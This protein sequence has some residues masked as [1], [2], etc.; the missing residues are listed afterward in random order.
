MKQELRRMIRQRKAAMPRERLQAM[1]ESVCRQVMLSQ[2]WHEAKVLLLYH[3]L[4]DEVD[5]ALLIREAEACGKQVLLPVVVGDVL[6]LRRYEGDQ[7]M[8][9][10]PFG[11]KEP[12]GTVFPPAEY[13]QITLAIVPGMAFD[14]EGYR[15]GRGRGYYDKLLPLLSHAWKMGICWDF[16]LLENIPCEPHDVKMDCVIR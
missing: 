13:G 2:P 14:C 3:S 10:G 5:T 11:I 6:E 15:L 16:Q 9:L 8:Q 4:P 1:S 12:T 7:S